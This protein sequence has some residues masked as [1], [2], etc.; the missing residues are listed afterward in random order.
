MAPV[1]GPVVASAPPTLSIHTKVTKLKREADTFSPLSPDAPSDSEDSTAG[2]DSVAAD[3]I[4][5]LNDE[6]SSLTTERLPA[7]RNLMKH[8]GKDKTKDNIKARILRR[9]ASAPA[10]F[11]DA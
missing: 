2:T 7:F 10:A 11:L 5:L 6:K 8:V 4:A 3:M 1:G 9:A